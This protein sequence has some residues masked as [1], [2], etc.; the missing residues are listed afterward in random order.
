MPLS[1]PPLPASA[2][3]QSPQTHALQVRL[4]KLHCSKAHSS[5][6]GLDEEDLLIRRETPID[7]SHEHAA[8]KELCDL[9]CKLRVGVDQRPCE[10]GSQESIV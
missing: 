10:T 4:G 3:F 2:N 5:W 7:T 8:R 6:E 9:G 1:L